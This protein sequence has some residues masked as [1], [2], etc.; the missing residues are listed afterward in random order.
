MGRFLE[1]KAGRSDL[2]DPVAIE[3][4]RSDPMGRSWEPAILISTSEILLKSRYVRGSLQRTLLEHLR[5]RLRR[6]GFRDFS[7]GVDAGRVV[8]SGLN[9]ERAVKACAQIFGVAAA[10]SAIRISSE[11]NKLIENVLQYAETH[12]SKGDSF[13]VRTRIVG[14]YPMS[15]RDIER[16]AGQT[17]CDRLGKDNVR[18]DLEHPVKTIHI[19]IRGKTLYLY[20]NRTEGCGGLPYGSQGRLVGVLSGDVDS[21]VASWLMMKR[22]SHIIPLLMDEIREKD[23]GLEKALDIAR[24]LRDFAPVDDYRVIVVPVQEIMQ[25]IRSV[26]ESDLRYILHHR[27]IYRIACSIAEKLHALGIVVGERLQSTSHISV[28]LPAMNEAAKLLVH[29][30]LI[31]LDDP[32]IAALAERIGIHQIPTEKKR[33]RSAQQGRPVSFDVRRIGPIETDLK[34]D[35]LDWNALERMK[36]IDLE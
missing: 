9:D 12:F 3:P 20:G 7:T 17:I 2:T 32:E 24:R 19:E 10:A 18:V 15:S 34:M 11:P 14:P 35:V 16:D 5:W 29:R 25:S 13:A 28:N 31:G 1:R 21:A 30:P 23:H 36:K 27:M 22:G 26:D 4:N 8:I 6:A 33:T